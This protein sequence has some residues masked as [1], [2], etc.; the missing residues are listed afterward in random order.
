VC[1]EGYITPCAMFSKNKRPYDAKILPP[2]SRLRANVSD[3]ASS[4]KLTAARVVELARDVNA[5]ASQELNDLARINI[6]P[7]NATRGLQRCLLKDSHWPH[8]YWAEIR[9]KKISSGEEEKQWMAF[10]LPHEYINCLVKHGDLETLLNADGMDP[11]TLAH[12]RHCESEAGCRLLGVGFWGDEVP[13][14]WDRTES[15]SAVGMDLPGL[16]DTK[17]GALR[18]PITA[19][20]SKQVGEHT[21]HDVFEVIAWSV[22]IGSKG[23]E[24]TSRH[25][26]QPWLR[27]DK[28]RSKVNPGRS[29]GHKVL[30][31]CAFCEARMDWVFLNK[32]FAFPNH[33][34]G[35]GCCW[36]CRCKPE[37]VAWVSLKHNIWVVLVKRTPY[38]SDLLTKRGRYSRRT[39]FVF[40]CSPSNLIACLARPPG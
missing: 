2:S 38:C 8:L 36:V 11:R 39:P 22:T 7:H 3:L 26:Q 27:S 28:S 17:F 13:C 25:D 33:N 5:V 34:T 15:I 24:C 4:R 30:Q 9:V 10:I 21:W 23:G 16:G 19:I 32:V 40:G 1:I 6:D 14:N 18:M 37:Q 31:R 20:S 29:R 12:L 35:A